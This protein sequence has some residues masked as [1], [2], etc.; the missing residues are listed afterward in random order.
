[1]L[2]LNFVIN[3]F[4]DIILSYKFI[5]SIGSIVIL[6]LTNTKGIHFPGEQHLKETQSAAG[7]VCAVNGNISHSYTGHLKLLDKGVSFAVYKQMLLELHK[8]SKYRKH[9]LKSYQKELSE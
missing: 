3:L 8:D 2:L 6:Y 5:L 9:S 1:M 7:I 4:C